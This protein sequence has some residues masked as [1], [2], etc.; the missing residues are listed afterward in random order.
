M[1]GACAGGIGGARHG[2]WGFGAVG[3]DGHGSWGHTRVFGTSRGCMQ[4]R[5]ARSYLGF[6]A[7]KP[8]HGLQLTFEG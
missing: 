8:G 5:L 3:G 4:D 1:E 6:G 2:S 7:Y